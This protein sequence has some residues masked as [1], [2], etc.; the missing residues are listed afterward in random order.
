M[1]APKYEKQ[2]KGLCYDGQQSKAYIPRVT[3]KQCQNK[4]SGQSTC[5]GYAS[6]RNNLCILTFDD[7]KISQWTAQTYLAYTCYKKI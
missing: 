5:I 2:W 7:E 1:I 4:C 6:H 3:P